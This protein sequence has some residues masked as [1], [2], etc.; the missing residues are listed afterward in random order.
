[1]KT[2]LQT[3]TPGWT[4]V[5]LTV[6][7][8]TYQ[9]SYMCQSSGAV[10]KSRL[11]SWNPALCSPY[12]LSGHKATMNSK[13]CAC[14]WDVWLHLWLESKQILHVYLGRNLQSPFLFCARQKW[15]RREKQQRRVGGDWLKK[16]GRHK[17]LG[18]FFSV[19]GSVGER[20]ASTFS[21][22]SKSYASDS[23]TQFDHCIG[24]HSVCFL[25]N[26]THSTVLGAFCGVFVGVPQLKPWGS[27][28]VGWEGRACN[29]FPAPVH[30]VLHT[31]A[32]L[33]TTAAAAFPLERF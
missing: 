9:S 12:S 4:V 11:P 29:H 21:S 32:V 2:P 26:I 33:P 30:I 24:G 14:K 3:C 8:K 22:A 27:P 5:R 19:W 20:M 10:W 7:R 25:T 6:N 28:N 17:F 16:A 13:L 1:M 15:W 18:W 31:G 23:A